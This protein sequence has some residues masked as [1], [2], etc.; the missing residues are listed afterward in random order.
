MGNSSRAL[1]VLEQASL[2]VS[3]IQKVLGIYEEVTG[4]CLQARRLGGHRNTFAEVGDILQKI[5]QTRDENMKKQNCTLSNILKLLCS[6]CV[7]NCS[8]LTSL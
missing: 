2:R 5:L 4:T 1:S 7:F 3:S 8:E 6:F